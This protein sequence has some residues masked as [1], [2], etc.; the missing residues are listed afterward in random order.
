MLELALLR[1]LV[2]IGIGRKHRRQARHA[3][4]LRG[5]PYH[6]AR[7]VVR[8]AGPHRNPP[9][10]R[11]DDQPHRAQPLIFVQR[12]ASRPV[13]RT[14]IQDGSSTNDIAT[15]TVDA[16]PLGSG[17]I[18]NGATAWVYASGAGWGKPVG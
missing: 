6:H 7:R 17:E 15:V 12:G 4:Q 2:V 13:E 5:L 10:R 8:A 18:V 14:H 3:P 16:R 11:V 1:G 9:R